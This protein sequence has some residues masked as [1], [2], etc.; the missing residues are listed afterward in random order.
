MTSLTSFYVKLQNIYKEKAYSD[1]QKMFVFVNKIT[2]SIKFDEVKIFCENCWTLEWINYRTLS[3]EYS[4]PL[5]LE[6]Y[7]N[8]VYKWYLAVRGCQIYEERYQAYV[9]T[10]DKEELEKIVN[11]EIIKTKFPGIL[12]LEKE[13]IDEM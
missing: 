9:K 8:T 3:Q 12:P 1:V 6:S 11:E 7:E 10:K 13:I 5:P 4:K 2:D